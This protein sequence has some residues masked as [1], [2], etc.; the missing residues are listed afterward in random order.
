M[1]VPDELIFIILIFLAVYFMI[2]AFEIPAELPKGN[3]MSFV[4]IMDYFRGL[5]FLLIAAVFWGV[6]AFYSFALDNCSST[7][8]VCFTSPTY[9][10]TTSS[11]V[12]SAF[13]L[14]LG[15]AFSGLA[16][17]CV[18]VALVAILYEGYGVMILKSRKKM[19]EGDM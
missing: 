17:L 10:T 1:I 16:I 2:L 3:A 15:F 12:P 14:P 4:I 9:S 18:I 6:L 5:V 11:V 7:F 13:S 8:G 19:I